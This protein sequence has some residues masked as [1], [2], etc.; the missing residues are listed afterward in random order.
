MAEPEHAGLISLTDSVLK[1]ALSLVVR[2]ESFHAFIAVLCDQVVELT[3][4]EGI[5]AGSISHSGSLLAPSKRVGHESA[6]SVDDGSVLVV[7]SDAV[8]SD[9]IPGLAKGRYLDAV[10]PGG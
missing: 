5:G 4:E 3:I 2:E 1:G 10:K 6:F 8:A 9:V 7:A